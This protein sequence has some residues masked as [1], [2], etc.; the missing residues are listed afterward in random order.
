[1]TL[2]TSQTRSWLTQLQSTWHKYAFY[3]SI[4]I[5]HVKFYPQFQTVH[6]NPM[7]HIFKKEKADF[8]ISPI[9]Y[10]V[11]LWIYTVAQTDPQA[12]DLKR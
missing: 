9:H 6:P 5:Y 4:L 7:V 1:M 2:P 12:I 8:Q 10:H 11:K 3:S